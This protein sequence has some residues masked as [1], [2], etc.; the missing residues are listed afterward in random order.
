MYYT[1]FIGYS[2]WKMCLFKYV[3]LKEKKKS[4]Q[5]AGPSKQIMNNQK[6]VG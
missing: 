1:F 4:A 2:L 3:S 6:T 5:T